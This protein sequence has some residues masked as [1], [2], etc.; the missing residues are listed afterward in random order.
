MTKYHHSNVPFEV[1]NS[2]AAA[3]MRNK[4]LR[5]IDAAREKS[6]AVMQTVL[7]EIPR[8]R[9]RLITDTHFECTELGSLR[10]VY[11][12]DEPES[13]H[14][15]ALAKMCEAV[16]LPASAIQG[17]ASRT[18]TEEP[19]W[20]AK[21]AA[22]IMNKHFRNYVKDRT[23]RRLI[24]SVN[25]QTRGFLSDRYQRLHPGVLL[26]AFGEACKE[27]DL[28]PYGGHVGDT[29]FVMRATYTNVL[30]PIKDEVLGIGVVFKESPYGDGASEL[31]L[32]IERMWC[33]NKAITTSELKK[34][35]L[36]SS[37][38]FD[39]AEA[40]EAYE[41]ASRTMA[42]QIRRTMRDLFAPE[43]IKRLCDIVVKAHQ[44]KVNHT[45]FENFLKKH[46]SVEDAEAVKTMYRSTDITALPAGD[47]W[48]RASNAL[49][50]YAGQKAAEDPEA[51][52]ELQKLAGAVLRGG[53][54]IKN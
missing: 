9:Y 7:S 45:E 18:S 42:A 15:F 29:R 5:E 54:A 30:E 13:V 36:G 34:V 38:A 10:V 6:A 2:E 48:W 35:H 8:D 1:A 33:T 47:S 49:S 39:L 25:G 20:G 4:L 50:W 31:S 46:L 28:A 26:E 22:E 32:Q 19:L 51:A 41:L 14:P 27:F 16:G 11:T 21:L 3:F 43:S 53:R 37:A 24:R 52:F 23:N 44:T 17:I 12:N 40:D